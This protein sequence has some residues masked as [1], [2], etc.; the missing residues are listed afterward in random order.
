MEFIRAL[1]H[2][3]FIILSSPVTN[4]AIAL[5]SLPSSEIKWGKREAQSLQHKGESKHFPLP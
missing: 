5:T 1:H 4:T 3:L 2:I